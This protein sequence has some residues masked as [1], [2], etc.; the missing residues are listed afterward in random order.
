MKSHNLRGLDVCRACDSNDLFLAIDLGELP[1]A[2][3]LLVSPSDAE[4]FPLKMSIC[5]SCGLGQ[6]QDVVTPERLFL[7]Y[8]YLSSISQTFLQHASTFTTK[9]LVDLDWRQGDWV[10]E[11]AS[12]DGYLLQY[13]SK[14]GIEV[15][16]IEPA[17]NIAELASSKGIETI[18]GFFGLELAQDILRERGYPRLI[19][20]N[21][22]YAH[23]PD[24]QDFTEGLSVLMDHRTQVSIENPSIMNLLVGLQFDSI[25]HEHFSYLS[26]TSVSNI[27]ERYGISLIDVEIIATHGGSNRYW[28]SKDKSLKNPRVEVLKASE[29]DRGLL[30]I[31]TWAQ[32]S[33][34]VSK[35]LNDFKIFISD[36]VSRGE[37]VAGYGAAAKASTLINASKI[38]PGEIKFIIDESHEKVG[39]F[40]PLA[41][42][43][44][45]S[46]DSEITSTIRHIVIFPW[47]LVDEIAA[48]VR[49]SFHNEVEIW[50]VIP[51]LRKIA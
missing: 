36:S 24:I 26:A 37:N 20:A 5:R 34:K 10:L 12:N 29:R 48:K 13:F 14:A 6:V 45:V 39:R 7:D 46:K 44:I 18:S 11:I 32:F 50:C 38:L 23:V 40:M 47:N 35:I 17:L 42:I 16:G 1:I 33:T 8:R 4:T 22:V 2:N 30:D 51:E 41:Y 49:E 21:N 9:V 15:L 31:S 43:P 25:Y 28:L 27:V 3:E 19:L